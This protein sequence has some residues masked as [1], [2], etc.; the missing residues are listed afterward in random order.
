MRGG[1]RVRNSRKTRVLNC[2]CI[3]L[4]LLSGVVRLL[5]KNVDAASYNL[6][7]CTFFTAAAV[8][9]ISQ[10]QRR[11]LRAQTRRNLIAVGVFVILWMMLRTVKYLFTPYNTVA[12]R[13]C[14]YLYYLP[15]TFILLPML[16][17]VLQIGRA[18][19]QPLDRRWRLLY[20]PAFALVLGILTNDLHQLAFRFPEGIPWSDSAYE[21]GVLY[22]ASMAWLAVVFF[23]MVF[24]ALR[25]CAV[26]GNRKKLWMPL[27]PLASALFCFL[28][29]FIWGDGGVLSIYKVPEILCFTD[30]A[31]MEGLILA[32]L[33]PSN[34]GY[35][36]LWNA[37]SIG[38]GIMAS[39]GEMRRSASQTIA[40][41]PAQV[42]QA[43]HGEILLQDGN[44]SLRSHRIH[45]GYGF[46]TKDT[47][48]LNRLNRELAELGDVLTEENT[49]LD[50]ENRLAQER[51]RMEQQS[52]LY[53]GIAQSV[54][55]QLERINELLDHVPQ[56]EMAF[57]RSMKYACILN[58]YVKRHSN[59][60]LLQDQSNR[61]DG[62]ELCLAIGES[63]EYLR[64]YGAETHA[65]FRAQGS[66]SGEKLL[67][68]YAVFEAVLEAALPDVDAALVT[69][70]ISEAT[71]ELRMELNAPSRL[72]TQA[73]AERALGL[74]QA[75]VRVDAE[76]LT[77]YL[78][79]L[80]PAGGE[81]G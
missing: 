36:E 39:S 54:K 63:M 73:E 4:V 79:L 33:L 46:W 41:K 24:I 37:S 7:I 65:Q 29:Y 38:A 68:A 51:V 25:R 80:I 60:L 9:W 56:E 22:F 8:I 34:D 61:I 14:W 1:F 52:R 12:E 13:Y 17:S 31:F 75:A 32:G 28:S 45:G 81:D 74:P 18:S 72:L 71:L 26:H 23:A 76:G 5:M 3:A 44:V 6:L 70:T 11:L 69:L 55:P 20:L 40:V 66:I 64:L 35:D 16:F 59:L 27:A 15:Q 77:E 2:V 19:D 21:H 42:R 50:A 78:T 57:E 47:S 10:L 43:E 58:A 53:D 67:A 30:C 48:E 49:M 62:G